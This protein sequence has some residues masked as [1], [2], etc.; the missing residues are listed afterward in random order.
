[1]LRAVLLRVDAL[2]GL[3]AVTIAVAISIIVGLIVPAIALMLLILLL[4]R[5][6]RV[7]HTGVVFGVL[8]KVFRQH[9]VTRRR[10]IAR[11]GQVTVEHLLRCSPYPAAGAIRV[12]LLIADVLLA[13]AARITAATRPA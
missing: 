10:R 6:R 3:V 1:L 11:Q 5:R 4:R 13:A 9:R 12:H 8:P 2:V 7:Q